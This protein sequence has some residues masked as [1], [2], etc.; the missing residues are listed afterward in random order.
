MK[1]KFGSTTANYRYNFYLFLFV[2]LFSASVPSTAFAHR[3]YNEIDACRISVGN[4]VIHFTAYTAASGGKGLCR[5]IPAVGPT[6]LVFDYEGQKLRSTTVAFE[7]T[8]EP[9]GTRVFYQAPEKVKKGTVDAKVDF[10]K[11]GAS[12]Y[13]AHITI[14]HEGK[15][16]D[17]HL[18]FSVGL[19]A[20]ASGTNYFVIILVVI[21]IMAFLAMVFMSKSKKD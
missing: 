14:E 7:I 9:G 11:H 8:K 10:S 12:N 5:V 19:E 6:D 13:L 16:L 4:E 20:T 15:K 21:L 3:S 1:A 18:P 17:S 2:F